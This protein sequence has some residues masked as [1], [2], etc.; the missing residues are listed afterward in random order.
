[1][2]RLLAALSLL[3]LAACEA[4]PTSDKPLVQAGRQQPRPGLWVI[5]ADNCPAPTSPDVGVW[6]DCSMPVWVG[7][8]RLTFTMLAPF[9]SGLVL[10]DGSPAIA[11]LETSSEPGRLPPFIKPMGKQDADKP[12]ETE[13]AYF[14]AQP[15]G[16]SPFMRA[17]VW[18]IPCPAKPPAAPVG[19]PGDD[20]DDDT[21][22]AQP[23]D[24]AAAGK[25]DMAGCKV[26]D[27]ATLRRWA[28]DAVKARPGYQ[29]RWMAP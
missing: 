12:R 18:S 11:Q 1:M 15:E 2:K 24:A 26:E 6:P 25:G 20:E 17:R 9:Q 4:P 10:A 7:P 3:A 5:L 13:Y 29:A 23:K 28:S 22:N 14:A 21:E 19:A 27:A 8:G 16:A